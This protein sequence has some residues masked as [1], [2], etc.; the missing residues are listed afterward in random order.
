MWT[1]LS[2]LTVPVELDGAPRRSRDHAVCAQQETEL[3]VVVV[4]FVV[5]Y[6]GAQCLQGR[7]HTSPGHRCS[8]P[9]RE[10]HAV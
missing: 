8:S 7:I 2:C 4:V 6:P 5:V 3:A 1:E 9:R 10:S